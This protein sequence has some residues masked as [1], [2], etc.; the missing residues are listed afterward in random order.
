MLSQVLQ[1]APSRA[2]LFPITLSFHP[3]ADPRENVIAPSQHRQFHSS[4]EQMPSFTY[5]TIMMSPH[6]EQKYESQHTLKTYH[7]SPE[8]SSYSLQTTALPVPPNSVLIKTSHSGICHTDIHAKPSGCGLGHEGIG[9]I[10][11]IGSSVT[12]FRVGDRVGWGWLHTSCKS[13]KTC[14]TGKSRAKYS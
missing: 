3:L 5:N 10:T 8:T 7:F 12:N 13:C 6:Q 4:N 14:K 9:H 2:H 11:A 1:F